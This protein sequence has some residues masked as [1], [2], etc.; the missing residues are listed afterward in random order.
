MVRI[1][2]LILAGLLV[3]GC[4]TTRSLPTLDTG[5]GCRGVGLDAR[6]AGDPSDPRLVWLLDNQGGGREEVVWPTG[7]SARFTPQVEVLDEHG[8]VAFRQGDVV[9]G[10]C[11]TG[12]DAQGPLMIR[13]GY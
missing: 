13:A 1:A 6:I 8:M 12:P 10:G 9:S 7:Y 5:G 2:G 11:V 4:A 3:A